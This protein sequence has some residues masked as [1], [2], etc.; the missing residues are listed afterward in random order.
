MLYLIKLDY[1]WN[2]LKETLKDILKT[3]IIY[4]S[5]SYILHKYY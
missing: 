2:V 3:Y 1:N 5:I 4:V